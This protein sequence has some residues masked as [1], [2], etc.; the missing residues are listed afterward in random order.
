MQE[1]RVRDQKGTAGAAVD[2]PNDKT[3]ASLASNLYNKGKVSF[4]GDVWAV[5]FSCIMLTRL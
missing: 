3:I 5:S 1:S 4:G 2:F